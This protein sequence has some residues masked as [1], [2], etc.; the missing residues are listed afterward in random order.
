MTGLSE[1][2]WAVRART[3]LITCELLS[4]EM[5]DMVLIRNVQYF[6]AINRVK[7]RNNRFSPSSLQQEPHP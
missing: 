3:G 6:L 5:D 7:A 2:G 1:G 4:R